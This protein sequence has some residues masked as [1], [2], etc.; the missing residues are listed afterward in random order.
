MAKLHWE[1]KLVPWRVIC[2][3]SR[4]L[5]RVATSW[6]HSF[7]V[8]PRRSMFFFSKRATDSF[9]SVLNA[10]TRCSTVNGFSARGAD[11]R[12]VPISTSPCSLKPR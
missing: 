2:L 4:A 10:S 7:T 9:A 8:Y 5:A 6:A 1:P 3:Y 11:M 12:N